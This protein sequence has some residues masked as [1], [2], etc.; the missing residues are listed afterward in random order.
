MRT[1]KILLIFGIT[2]FMGYQLH[3]QEFKRAWHWYFGDQVGLDFSGG[4]PVAVSTGSGITDLESAGATISDADGSLQFYTN[5]G[6]GRHWCTAGNTGGIW[7]KNHVVMQNGDLTNTEGGAADSR[8]S[9]II[10][11]RPGSN[12]E[13]FLFT[14]EEDWYSWTCPEPSPGDGLSL[15]II[16]MNQNGGLGAVTTFDQ[17]IYTPSAEALD[18]TVHANGT[19][20]W[21]AANDSGSIIN[22][23]HVSAAGVIDTVPNP[24]SGMLKMFAFSPDASMLLAGGILYD[25]DNDSGL[26][27]NPRNLTDFSSYNKVSFSPNSKYLYTYDDPGGD[28]EIYQFDLTAP[29]INASK[30]TVGIITDAP[31]TS[32]Q[33]GNMQL[34]P[35]GKIYIA[36]RNGELP[37]IDCPNQQGTNCNVRQHAVTLP[38]TMRGGLPNFVDAWFASNDSCG[39]PLP[40][41]MINFTAKA[42]EIN[43]VLEWNTSMEYNNDYFEIQR[44][45]DGIHFNA[46]GRV[47]GNG[48][49]EQRQKYS[50]TDG[51][52]LN[53]INYYR[54]KQVDFDGKDAQT[55]II[56]IDFND[57]MHETRLRLF[58]NPASSQI[59]VV[60]QDI[61]NIF[62]ITI[63][64][65]LGNELK[66][67][68]GN[69]Q[70]AVFLD[71]SELVPGF[72][73]VRLQQSDH[74]YINEMI[75]QR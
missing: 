39:E 37:A 35:D 10:L 29:D 44:S 34:G 24:V 21:V 45:A 11:P 17:K 58:P 59:G 14:M 71:V 54:L 22:M 63:T 32:D 51:N 56:N 3:S 48:T 4:A 15:F 52:P 28:N 47:S 19:D 69:N 16:D 55:R 68:S 72:Y 2:I 70:N 23:F 50:Y 65:I 75:I 53:G 13:Y 40:V 9:A 18:A 42:G 67:V 27:S 30:I 1:I 25:F 60:I 38:S 49:S 7:N 66:K 57:N 61:N 46:I 6:Y 26:L 12:T 36:R 5:G 43:I 64:D 33:L 31:G 41:E 62:S 73:T 8:Q 20:Y 74:I